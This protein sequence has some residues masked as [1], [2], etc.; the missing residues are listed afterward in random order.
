MLAVD[1]GNTKTL[2]A[3]ADAAGRALGTG[4]GGARTS[5]TPPRRTTRSTRSRPPSREALARAGVAA[6]RARRR[7]VQPRGRRL[8]GGLRAARGA[9]CASGSGCR[10]PA[11]RQ[12]RARRAARRVARLDR[13]RDR[14]RHLQRG[15]RAPP[16]RARVP[17][18][19]L[20]RRRRRARPRRAGAARRLPRRARHGAADVLTERALALYGAE[21]AI[22]LLHAFTRRGGLPEA[23]VDRLAPVVLDA[24]DE[25][26]AVAQAIVADKG[27]VLGRQGARAPRSSGC[28]WRHAGRAHRRRVRAPDRAARRRDDGRA[29]RRDRR[30]ATR[31]AD[32]GRAAARARPARRRGRR[33]AVAAGL[34]F[35]HLDGRSAAWAGSPSRA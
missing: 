2:A 3:V 30:S 12:R 17:P 35:P 1:G 25:G 18:R 13:R 29:A 15:R 8:A 24:A 20:A 10:R 27:R 32:R 31:A 21:D 22:G 4:R 33:G 16:R 26:D 14:Q 7:R 6:G 23:E 5:T 19:L 9:R 28:R 34:P 11:R